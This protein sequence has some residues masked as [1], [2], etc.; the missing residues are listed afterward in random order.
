MLHSDGRSR[1]RRV[2]AG[3]AVF[4]GTAGMVV[5]VPTPAPISADTSDDTRGGWRTLLESFGAEGASCIA[6]CVAIACA[7]RGSGT[8][9]VSCGHVCAISVMHSGH[10]VSVQHRHVLGHRPQGCG[11]ASGCACCGHVPV[12]TLGHPT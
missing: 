3:A 7:K 1:G 2:A 5:G 11:V 8:G 12:S 9:I 10:L 4:G 6:L